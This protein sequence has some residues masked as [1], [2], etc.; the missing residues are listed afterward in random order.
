MFSNFDL[1]FHIIFAIATSLTRFQLYYFPVILVA[2]SFE[3]LQLSC[4]TPV[5]S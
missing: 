4:G 2:Y 1:E 3:S 5:A